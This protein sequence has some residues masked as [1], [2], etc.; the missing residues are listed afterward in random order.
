MAVAGGS[1]GPLIATAG[2]DRAVCVL[3]PRAGFAVRSRFTEHTD[4]IY[5]L[6]A[7]G[8]L[9]FSGAGNGMLICHDVERGAR[10]GVGANKAAARC[11]HLV[12]GQHLVVAGDDGN[13]LVFQV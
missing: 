8:P 7:R 1:G 10:W 12:G 9:L 11:V 3:D 5:S 6:T 2:A 13:A 4:F